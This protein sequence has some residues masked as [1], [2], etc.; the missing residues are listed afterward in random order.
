[1]DYAAELAEE[2]VAPI[3][4]AGESGMKV[5]IDENIPLLLTRRHLPASGHD[6]KN[7]RGTPEQ[8]ID[9]SELWSIA[10]FGTT[11]AGHD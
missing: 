10:V 9:D 1:L 4:V 11:A 5:L 7:V 2:Q 6:L 3:E 8:G